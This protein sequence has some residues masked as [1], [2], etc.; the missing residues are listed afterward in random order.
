M[1]SEKLYQTLCRQFDKADFTVE[2]GLISWKCE[3]G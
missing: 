1:M 2:H 3:I